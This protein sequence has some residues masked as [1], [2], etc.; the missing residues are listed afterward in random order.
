LDFLFKHT[1]FLYLVLTKKS[2]MTQQTQYSQTTLQKMREQYAAMK[3]YVAKTSCTPKLIFPQNII[4]EENLE[5]LVEMDGLTSGPFSI[6]VFATERASDGSIGVSP[7]GTVGR[8]WRSDIVKRL[9]LMRA[10]A[11]QDYAR[12]LD[13]A[14]FVRQYLRITEGEELI[15]TG[16]KH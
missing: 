12:F 15:P 14:A 9:A 2:I 7:T 16:A 1:S 11:P 4:S 3:D 8:L 5:W 6:H 13:D 10:V